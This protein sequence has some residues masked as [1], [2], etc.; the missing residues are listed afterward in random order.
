MESRLNN[1]K[2]IFLLWINWLMGSGAIVLLIQLSLFVKPLYMPFVAFG[3]QFILF[4]LIKRNREKELPVCY[5]FPFVASRIMFWSGA[6]MLVINL[7]YSKWLVETVFGSTHINPHIPFLCILIVCPITLIC[8][9]WVHTHKRTIS[10]CRDCKMRSGTA[11]E[12]GF[13]GKIFTREGNYQIDVCLIV[14]AVLTLL[15][16]I[17]YVIVYINSSLNHTDRFVFFIAPALAWVGASVYFALRYIGIWGYYC[18]NIAGSATRHGRSTLLRYILIDYD[19]ICLSKPQSGPDAVDPGARYFDTPEASYISWRKHVS[20]A[21][22]SLHF[23]NM[24]DIV[25]SDIRFFYSTTSGNADCNIFRYFV[26]LR[27]EQRKAFDKKNPDCIWVTFRELVQM[28]ND[29]RL[30]PLMSAEFVRL[31]TMVMAWKTYDNRGRRRYKIK[32]YKPMFRFE[33]LSSWDIDFNDPS[34]LY[35]ADNNQDTPF[36][37]LRRLWRKYING[38]GNYIEEINPETTE[39]QQ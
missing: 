20:M 24:T 6:T 33:N 32:H 39:S 17:Y 19:L 15:A 10:F 29:H 27:P 31:Y 12:R 37:H 25:D 16:W 2:G 21:D 1:G 4:L 8:C 18:Q 3:I 38:V 7:L 14:S 26:F 30:N 34:W 9:L 23:Y 11:A 5:L 22:A 36:Y 13:L 35:V 28:L